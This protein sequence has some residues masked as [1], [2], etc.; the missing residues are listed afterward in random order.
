MELF[1]HISIFSLLIGLAIG[2]TGVFSLVL[3]FLF[4]KDWSSGKLW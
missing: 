2:L 3:L 4:I 1:A